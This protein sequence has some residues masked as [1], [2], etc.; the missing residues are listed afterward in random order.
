MYLSKTSLNGTENISVTY[1]AEVVLISQRT[2]TLSTFKS[3]AQGD[4]PLE[5]GIQNSKSIR[6]STSVLSPV[7]PD[8]ITT[9]ANKKP[10]G[11]AARKP[12]STAQCEGQR[13]GQERFQ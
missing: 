4:L 13:Q 10:K 5:L 2:E 6:S 12:S 3:H 8:A 1:I 11:E 9:S 7:S